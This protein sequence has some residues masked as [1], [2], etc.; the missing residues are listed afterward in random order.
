ME[1]EDHYS[2]LLGVNSPWEISGVDLEIKEQQV[3][4][5]YYRVH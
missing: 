1:V 4:R 5:Y 3:D 2:Q